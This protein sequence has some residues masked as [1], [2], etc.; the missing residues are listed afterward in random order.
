[1]A[2]LAGLTI[3]AKESLIMQG[4]IFDLDGTLVD[5]LPCW[6]QMNYA[7]FERFQIPPSEEVMHKFKSLSLADSAGLVR[8]LY[9]IDHSEE[10]IVNIWLD[11]ALDMY[12]NRVK[13]KPY[14]LEYL[15]LQKSNGVKFGVATATYTNLAKACL[16][17]NGV[18]DLFEFVIDVNLHNTTKHEPTIYNIAQD[19]LGVDINNCVVFED[20]PYAIRTANNAGYK[21]ICVQDSSWGDEQSTITGHV[22]TTILSYEELMV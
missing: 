18:L 7:F 13:L 1:M 20:A 14:V 19:M 15:Q 5:S 9:D 12:T 21:V 2:Q 17:A 4:I 11:M 8:E 22:E 10:D 6:K 3:I 16:E